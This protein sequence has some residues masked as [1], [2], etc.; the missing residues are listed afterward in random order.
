MCF[1][2]APATDKSKIQSREKLIGQICGFREKSRVIGK[3]ES[4]RSVRFSR[5]ASVSAVHLR[6]IHLDRGKVTAG[7]SEL[8]KLRMLLF[9]GSG[10]VHTRE[11]RLNSP[12]RRTSPRKLHAAVVLEPP[13]YYTV[14]LLWR[15]FQSTHSRERRD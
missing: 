8:I 5:Q 7:V 10:F 1:H 9:A 12:V 2:A 3:S 6:V 15:E 13:L 11:L 14:S 4:F